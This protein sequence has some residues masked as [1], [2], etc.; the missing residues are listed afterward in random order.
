LPEADRRIEGPVSGRVFKIERSAAGEKIAYVRIFSGTVRTRDKVRFGRGS[1]RKVSAISVL[2]RGSAFKIGPASAGE[3]AKL[4]GL[5]EIQVGD[6]I[7]S[8]RTQ[9]E[10]HH[11]APPTLET[12]VVSRYPGDKGAL[13]VALAQLA[14]QDP[15][16]NLRQDD[17]LG[18]TYISLYGEIQKEIIGSTLANDFG[19]EVSF[20]KTTTICIERPI[21]AGTAVERLREPP[22]PFLATVGLHV[23]PAAAG[24]GVE[25][26]LAVETL[27]TM[28]MAFFRAVQDTVRETLHQGIYGWEV[29]DCTV[30]MTHSGYLG[31]HSHAHQRF[32]KSMSS[33]GE[34]FRGLTPLVL[35]TALSR[36][37]TVVCEPIHRF[38]LDVSVDTLGL[39]LPAL[40]R[41]QAVP[42]M[43]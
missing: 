31:R 6:E 4:C 39:L 1:E 12:V 35:M 33:T 23:E 7:G 5:A 32:N 29:T 21:G 25:V 26:R 14:E 11:F 43:C 36:A 9:P 16:I 42:H 8:P 10:E 34:D 18:E 28:P 15:L 24:S 3:I 38:R 13:R 40:A 22:N 20:Q 19:L 2:A 30:T 37:R 27:G 41:I 17:T